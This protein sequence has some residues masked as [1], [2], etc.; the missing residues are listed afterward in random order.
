MAWSLLIM[1]LIPI[2]FLIPIAT[3][4]HISYL[5]EW[6]DTEGKWPIFK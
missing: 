6:P 3:Y 5:T 4:S 1:Q 2:G